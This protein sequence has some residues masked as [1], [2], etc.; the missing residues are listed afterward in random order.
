MRVVFFSLEF[1]SATFSGNGTYAQSQVR[2]LRGCGHDVLVV[3]GRPEA[4]AGMTADLTTEDQDSV[5]RLGVEREK[6]GV[7]DRHSPWESFARRAAEAETVAVIK[8]FGADVA[9]AV[10]WSGVGAFEATGLGAEL[11][12]VYLVYRIF[13]SNSAATATA[14][15]DN[16]WHGA[17]EKRALALADATVALCRHDVATLRALAA[18][19]GARI[20]SPIALLP[21]L[22]SP[23]REMAHAARI[24]PPGAAPAR[25]TLLCC[26]RLSPEKNAQ[27]FVELLENFAARGGVL[28]ILGVRAKMVSNTNSPYA[29]QLRARARAC[30]AE[31]V[32]TF[33]D[34]A[35]MAAH[36]ATALL[37]VHTSLNEAYGMTIV[38]AAAFEAPSVINHTTGDAPGP[39]GATDLLLGAGAGASPPFVAP[40]FVALD[41]ARGV[42]ALAES[43]EAALRDRAALAAL[44]A[45]A[46]HAALAWDEAANAEWLVVN[47][48]ATVVHPLVP[49][50]SVP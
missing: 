3:C 14:A 16:A 12:L 30:G 25:D 32:E 50:N 31:L 28:E 11:Q 35:Q 44:G 15:E 7:L 1:D 21:A 37:N 38:E 27:L 10:D 42:A 24:A 48:L 26:V 17:R 43:V 40:P 29:A 39:V 9:L 6:W 34:P 2:G 20:A 13:S 23:L 4:A 49:S 8:G 46:S 36:F 41:Y 45:A 18:G 33:Q 47:V 5:L 22:R 19:S